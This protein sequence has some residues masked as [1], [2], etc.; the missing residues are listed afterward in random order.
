MSQVSD[1]APGR[2]SYFKKN[3]CITLTDLLEL[4]AMAI[5]SC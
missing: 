1:V 5:D 4:T 2:A 3:T